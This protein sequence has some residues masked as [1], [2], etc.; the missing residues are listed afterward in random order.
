M[1][2]HTPPDRCCWVCVRTEAGLLAVC[3]PYRPWSPVGRNRGQASRDGPAMGFPPGLQA[4]VRL[5]GK[6]NSLLRQSIQPK[7]PFPGVAT[8]W[9][10]E[11]LVDGWM[12]GW[13]T[14][15]VCHMLPCICCQ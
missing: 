6:E 8:I 12:D 11:V 10:R 2:T 13:M 14:G 4:G 1:G 15:V 7:Q 3:K 9:K 5:T